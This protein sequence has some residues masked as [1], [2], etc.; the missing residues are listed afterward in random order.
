MGVRAIVK[1]VIIV[2]VANETALEI[3][4][5]SAADYERINIIIIFDEL[6]P[7]QDDGLR[8]KPEIEILFDCTF[9]EHHIVTRQA[10]RRPG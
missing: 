8:Q 5:P 2:A 7:G 9:G 3:S 6:D 10:G 4:R 1:F